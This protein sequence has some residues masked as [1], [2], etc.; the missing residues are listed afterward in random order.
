MASAQL[1]SSSGS[2]RS[3]VTCSSVAQAQSYSE[4]SDASAKCATHLPVA[5]SNV[6]TTN[7][8]DPVLV[9]AWEYPAN[10][11][12]ISAGSLLCVSIVSC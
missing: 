9:G 10:L 2:S 3:S 4:E 1:T 11:P 6:S 12:D 8:Q 5:S 7:G